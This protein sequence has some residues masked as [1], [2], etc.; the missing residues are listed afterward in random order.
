MNTDFDKIV[1]RKPY[2][3]VKFGLRKAY[4]GTED[5]DP[6]WVADMDFEV[7]EPINNAIVKRAAHAV[8]G[9]PFADDDFKASVCDWQWKQNQWK[10]AP[11]WVSGLP[12][13][14][15]ALLTAVLSF[16]A[17]SD[18][19]IVQPPVYFPF[20]DVIESVGRNVVKNPLILNNGRYEMDFD[21][22]QKVITDKTKMLL[23]CNPH[24][25][26]G[27]MWTKSEL[28][29]LGEICAQHQVLIIADEIHSDLTLGGRKH[30]PIA[31]ISPQ[32]SEITVT[33][34]SASKTFNLAGLTCAYTIISSDTLRRKFDKM[35]SMTHLFISNVFGLEATSAAYRS[36]SGWLEELKLYL[37]ETIA[38]MEV[39]FQE[40]LPQVKMM[41]PE[42]GYLVWLDFSA[43]GDPK[44]V[45][46][47]LIEEARVGL[48]HGSS[49]GAE[50]E[51]FHR[52][53]IAV[54]RAEVFSALSRIQK[55]FSN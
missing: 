7:A 34:S 15:P 42:A 17:P 46:K 45:R 25:P 51:N 28:T 5:I 13:V 4:F 22:L 40:N 43:C 44:A 36:G 23:L 27:R 16:S 32:I 54:R 49:F 37:E 12:G 10:V 8:Y 39:F 52:I 53:N 20:F 18:E 14:V 38:Q 6:L 35:L 9:Y 1:D 33:C 55:V 24:N 50:G 26:S 41:K 29:K 3:N 48:N 19:V 30:Q 21:H 2:N 47:K 11:E 31:K